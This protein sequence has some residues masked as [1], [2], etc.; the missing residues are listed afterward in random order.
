[1][2]IKV[3]LFNRFFFLFIQ[4]AHSMH[5]VNNNGNICCSEVINGL[6]DVVSGVTS[7]ACAGFIDHFKVGLK[8]C[9]SE[10]ALCNIN[11]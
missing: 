2:L 3:I 11:L 7:S 8:E 6:D 10:S 9:V 5:A 4:M 1:V